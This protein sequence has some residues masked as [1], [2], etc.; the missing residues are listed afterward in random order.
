MNIRIEN[1]PELAAEIMQKAAK[2]IANKVAD[3]NIS[4]W[5]NVD[6]L[7]SIN[8]IAVEHNATLDEF[9]VIYADDAPIAAA[10]LQKQNKA[11]LWSDDKP[12]LYGYRYAANPDYPMF[13]TGIIFEVLKQ[14]AN[15]IGVP[16]IRID[17]AEFEKPKLRLYQSVGFKIVGE[18]V[19]DEKCLLL[20]LDVNQK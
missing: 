15:S 2:R 9:F 5:W 3:K 10:I 13:R 4:N 8:Q 18:I 20:E 19:D 6:R 16:T 11:G 17:I 7:Q 1:N 14:Y 12:A